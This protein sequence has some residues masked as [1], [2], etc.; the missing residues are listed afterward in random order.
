MKTPHV[1]PMC[2]GTKKS[3]EMIYSKELGNV[4]DNPG[5]CVCYHKINY[6]GPYCDTCKKSL[7]EEYEK[8]S[9][10]NGEGIVWG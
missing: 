6:Y 10:C 8:C 4:V 2:N 1:C 3:K 7:Q 5:H 9:I